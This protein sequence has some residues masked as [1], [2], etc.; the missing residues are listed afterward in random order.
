MNVYCTM[1][2]TCVYRAQSEG[3]GGVNKRQAAEEAR[4]GRL[5]TAN[6][7][8]ARLAHVNDH[9]VNVN[10]AAHVHDLLDQ[11]VNG[12]VRARAVWRRD[13]AGEHAED[14]MLVLLVDASIPKLAGPH[15]RYS[16]SGWGHPPASRS[17]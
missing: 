7:E 13:R 10:V 8:V 5:P 2:C 17:G 14:V 11:A 9:R 6:H 12:N 15:P 16:G 4:P 1:A 3:K